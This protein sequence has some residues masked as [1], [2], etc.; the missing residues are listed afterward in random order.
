MRLDE[1]GIQDRIHGGFIGRVV[2]STMGAAVE[3]WTYEN[4]K[5]KHGTINKYVG[6]KFDDDGH[7]PG[8][9]N[10]D[11]MFEMVLLVAL[12]EKGREV[13][14]ADVARKWLE[15]IHPN[16]TFTAEK[17]ALERFKRGEFRFGEALVEGNPYHDY[18]GAQMRGE[19]PGWVHPG[20]MDAAVALAL[21]DAEVSHARDGVTGELFVSA[22]V[23]NAFELPADVTKP[24]AVQ[25]TWLR[26]IIEKSKP[27]I[28]AGSWYGKVIAK[29]ETLHDADP[30]GWERNL[31][32]LRDYASGEVLDALCAGADKARQDVLRKSYH[33]HVLPNAGII[34][35]ALLHGQGD[36]SRSLEI[37]ADCGMD[38]DCN[39]G[40]VGG[41]LGTML[42]A[43][44]VPDE[45]ARP[46]NNNFMTLV[47]DWEEEHL[48]TIA[49]RIYE[50]SKRLRG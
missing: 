17:V 12:E 34:M 14:T 27:V 8:I 38:A 19:L 1:K 44:N 40:N 5:K 2:G 16:F 25:F 3:N 22:M 36:F 47:K 11:E 28:P 48:D 35:L 49:T 21:V 15:L 37:C 46:L 9:P 39:C 13:A 6:F 10:D 33:V 43:E 18:I 29:A 41:I 31:L 20:N 4:I 50:A 32:A 45:W 24:G 30:A 7:I 26:K 42:G 23:A